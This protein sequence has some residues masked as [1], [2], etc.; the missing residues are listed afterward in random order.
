MKIFQCTNCSNPIF[1][2]NVTCQKCGYWL[3]YIDETQRMHALQPNLTSWQLTDGRVVS[4]CQNHGYNVC[5]WL[6]PAHLDG[7]CSACQLNHTIPNLQMN[8]ALEKWRHFELAK[9]R[10]IFSLRRMRLPVVKKRVSADDGLWFYF[11]DKEV[12]GKE[13]KMGHINGEITILISEADSVKRE[14]MR[15]DLQ[16]PYR[17][18]IGHLRHEIGH[19]YWDQLILK[20]WDHLQKFRSIFGDEQLDYSQ[21]I[22]AHY[23]WGPSPQWQNQFISA[24]ASSHPWE[25]WAETWAHYMHLMDTM[26]TAYHFGL[27]IEPELKNAEH[28]QAQATF[29]PYETNDFQQILDYSIPLFFAM[30]SINRSM[31]I[32]DLYPFVIS[33]PVIEKLSFIH[34]V[35]LANRV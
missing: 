6:V 14:E 9:H 10:L 27:D 31:G 16:E 5:N 20:N 1:F 18:M 13:I 11:V 12:E 21:A 32:S 15:K 30:N 23:N 2:E 3:G 29:D 24:Y 4:Y 33:D 8:T 17:T 26:E 28:M 34:A 19:Y 35:V 25:D 22:N 7:Y